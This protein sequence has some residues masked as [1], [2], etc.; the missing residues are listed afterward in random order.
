[1]HAAVSAKS[2]ECVRLLVAESPLASFVPNEVGLAHSAHGRGR[3]A[4]IAA[5]TTQAGLTPFSVADALGHEDM[6]ATMVQAVTSASSKMLQDAGMAWLLGCT[7]C[8]NPQIVAL[9]ALLDAPHPAHTHLIDPNLL[10]PLSDALLAVGQSGTLPLLP[11]S[12]LVALAE[13]VGAAAC[14]VADLDALQTESASREEELARSCQ[15]VTQLQLQLTHSTQERDALRC[16][17]RK[18]RTDMEGLRMQAEL[19]GS[20]ASLCAALRKKN[21]ELECRVSTLTETLGAAEQR[22]EEAAAEI[23]RLASACEQLS[24]ERAARASA[25]SDLEAANAAL[26]SQV[27]TLQAELAA[28]TKS[29]TEAE[30][31]VKVGADGGVAGKLERCLLTAAVC[32]APAR[33]WRSMYSTW[34]VFSACS[35]PS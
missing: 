6:K 4:H 20:T 35:L 17:V 31:A 26:V 24:A 18:L 21:A 5:R 2:H 32:S 23:W 12:T 8:H 3:A 29:A 15:Q 33:A 9:C 16:E 34:P 7:Q 13:R 28:V 14:A 10:R 25:G 19:S 30:R 11:K 27:R 22:G 1:M